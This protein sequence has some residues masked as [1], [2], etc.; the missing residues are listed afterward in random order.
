MSKTKRIG[1][2]FR[3]APK[4]DK[5]FTLLKEVMSFVSK[6]Y[7]WWY[8]LVFVLAV[9]SVIASVQ[10]TLFT[11][12]LID[13]YILPMIGQENPS[14]SALLKAIWRI[15]FFYAVGVIALLLQQFLLIYISQGV[16]KDLRIRLFEHM[17][18]LPI[19]YFDTHPH[20]DIMSIYSNDV[21]ML[22]QLL[23][24]SLPSVLQGIFQM[25][26]VL[27]NMFLL[28][29]ILSCVSLIMIFLIIYTSK[30]LASLSGK[31]YV[32]QQEDIAELDAYVEEMINGQKVIKSF[33]REVVSLNIFQRLNEKLTNSSYHANRLSM[34]LYPVNFQLSNINYALCACIGAYLVM[35]N[36]TYFSVGALASFLTFNKQFAGPISQIS[37]QINAILM[38]LAGANRIFR[39]LEEEKEIDE[40]KIRLVHRKLVEGKWEECQGNSNHW[41]WKYSENGEV[42]LRPLQGEV[43]FQKVDFSYDGKHKVL[44]DIDMYAKPG[45]KIALVGST[46]AGKTT[47]MNLLNRFYDVDQGDIFYDGIPIRDIRKEDLRKAL[48]IVLQDTRLFATSIK[49]N[50]RYGNLQ[51]SDEEVYEAARFANA[52]SFIS[53]LPEAYDTLLS[54]DAENLSQGQRQ[55]LAIARAAIA[56]PPVLILDEATSSIDTHTEALLQEGMDKLMKDRT[57]FVIAHRLSTI[58]NADCILVM[59]KGKIIERGS[60]QELLAKKGKYYQLSTGKKE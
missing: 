2:H 49:E 30:S 15:G 43:S 57:T 51:A 50:I 20:G 47:I 14:Y 7:G 3:H 16:L 13:R 40:G 44:S 35:Q 46:G 23:S 29:P 39:L 48:G 24:Q 18:F 53:C 32:K 11:K 10:G 17:Q 38:G 6:K 19:V 45:Q 31:F 59:E 27:V 8:F 26:L 58:R 52:D 4:V 36:P 54:M 34:V 56:N 33:N 5:P 9:V 25:L 60:H 41:A 42:F 21:D 12:T 37:S 28:S 55:L 22:R 1:G